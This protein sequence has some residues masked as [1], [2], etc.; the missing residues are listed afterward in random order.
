M[1]REEYLSA[2]E[3]ILFVSNKPVK[4]A[5]LSEALGIDFESTKELLLSL[6]DNLKGEG[7]NIRVVKDGYLLYPNEKY[8]RYYEKFIRK[9]RLILSKELLEVVAVLAKG[10]EN[11]EHIDK[12]RGVNSTRSLNALIKKGYVRKILLEGCIYYS[13]T[14]TLIKL[15]DPEVRKI[16]DNP[17]LFDEQR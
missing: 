1:K 15:I 6:E 4:A 3:S 5:A 16:I 7:F 9:K 11:K 10:K 8:R 17:D 2:I 14:E 12:M 13:L